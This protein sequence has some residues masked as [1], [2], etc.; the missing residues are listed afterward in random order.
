MDDPV[1]QQLRQVVAA[2]GEAVLQNS[3]QLE[4][5]LAGAAAGAPGKVKALLV[6][7]ERKA[8]AF[9][10]TWSKDAR[11]DKGTYEQM[12]QQIAAK[13]E[14]AKLMNAAAA[15][16]ALD[17]WA[18]ALGLRADTAGAPAPRVDSGLALVEPEPAPA[19][20]PPP[21]PEAVPAAPALKPESGL[22][23]VEPTKPPAAAESGLTL[24]E[25]TK[26]PAAATKSPPARES[27]PAA[28]A[29]KPESGL[30]LV[31]P[32]KPPPAAE[33]K[34]AAA[35]PARPV[36]NPAGAAPTRPVANPRIPARG[37]PPAGA[38]LRATAAN[39]YAPPAASVVDEGEGA[40]DDGFIPEGRSVDAGRGWSWVADAWTLF[41]GSPVIWIVNVVLFFV[42]L[43]VLQLVP[44]L[45]GIASTLLSPVLMGGLVL[46][47]HALHQGEPLEVRHLFAGFRE[48][49]GA[50]AMIGVLNFLG[51]LVIL[52]VVG[53]IVGAGVF[54]LMK[55]GAAAGAHG[56]GA[57]G[58]GLV[59]GVL[60]GLALSI[61]LLM[62]Y[63]FAPA[64]V[65]LN[66]LGA[67]EAMKTSFSACLKNMMPFL[68]YGLVGLVLAILA[69]IPVM[70]GWFVL[71]PIMMATLYTSYRDIFY[72][73]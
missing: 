36:A 25:P 70:L 72:E 21:A 38:A 56:A 29:L 27:V 44:F 57:I 4:Q 34:P 7:L 54:G 46:G 48:R 20:K 65:V 14:Q 12:R 10:L 8:V 51:T 59:L 67:L 22:T 41:K 31:E 69:S 60:V 33:A 61:P 26:P 23:L 49:A 45:G 1:V 62:A 35:T 47:A 13:F 3:T 42:I 43:I 5:L 39:P 64:L 50:L 40:G 37:A 30:T 17:A 58:I 63:W 9:L 68:V 71:A 24:V 55:G 32:T 19:P 73:A 6:L 11:P 52:V 15:G 2:H 66:E 28:P 18:T 16:W 53:I